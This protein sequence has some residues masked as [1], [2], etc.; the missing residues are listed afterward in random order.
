MKDLTK[1][2]LHYKTPVWDKEWAEVDKRLGTKA[3]GEPGYVDP[4]KEY[5][6]QEKKYWAEENER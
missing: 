2:G 5:K 1:D 6:E 4:E 3:P